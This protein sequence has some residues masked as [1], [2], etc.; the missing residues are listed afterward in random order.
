M[1]A[2]AVTRRRCSGRWPRCASRASSSTSSI[3][4]SRSRWSGRLLAAAARR[5][6]S[7]AQARTDAVRH[8]ASSSSSSLPSTGATDEDQ[9]ASARYYYLPKLAIAGAPPALGG[10]LP[11]LFFLATQ[12]RPGSRLH[13]ESLE[14][15]SRVRGRAGGRATRRSPA[16]DHGAG[17]RFQPP[18]VAPAA[19]SS[20]SGTDRLGA[21]RRSARKQRIVLPCRELEDRGPAQPTTRLGMLESLTSRVPRCWTRLRSSGCS[22]TPS[23][24]G[25]GCAESVQADLLQVTVAD[26]FGM[27]TLQPALRTR[28]PRSRC[29][30]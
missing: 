14:L 1:N 29:D 2:S 17:A 21:E 20:P 15:A 4:A 18:A 27:T 23:R 11:P 16:V 13:Q 10:P 9:R 8:L 12:L 19:C 25:S 26:V 24:C 6:H 30:A 28:E 7:A 22:R 5:L 3:R